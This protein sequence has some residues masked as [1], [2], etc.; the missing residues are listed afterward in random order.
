MILTK[1]AGMYR[2]VSGMQL[3]CRGSWT[4]LATYKLPSTLLKGNSI[5]ITLLAA[6]L[7]LCLC[8]S[9]DDDAVPRLLSL[10]NL[11]VWVVSKWTCSFT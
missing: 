9:A 4:N 2:M 3:W 6:L 1:S 11:S 8:L 5:V 7:L 10:F